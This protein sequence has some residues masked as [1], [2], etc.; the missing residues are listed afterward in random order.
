MLACQADAARFIK[1]GQKMA[2]DKGRVLEEIKHQQ[3]KASKSSIQADVGLC[4][5]KDE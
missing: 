3:E 5:A 1:E 2:R 4:C